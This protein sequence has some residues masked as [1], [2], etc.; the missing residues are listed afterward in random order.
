MCECFKIGGPFIAE[1]PNCP[2]HGRE[3]QQRE[4]DHEDEIASLNRKI[5]ILAAAI[6]DLA[7]IVRDLGGRVY[8]MENPN[9]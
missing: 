6:G 9:P 3:A 7:E 2:I 4:R 8:H 5:E 1:D